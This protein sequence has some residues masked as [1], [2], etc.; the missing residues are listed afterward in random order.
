MKLQRRC[1][2]WFWGVWRWE[3]GGSDQDTLYEN[4]ENK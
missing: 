2:E 4:F 1:N 3:G